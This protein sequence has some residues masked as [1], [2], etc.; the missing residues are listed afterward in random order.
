MACCTCT[1]VVGR[2]CKSV[3]FWVFLSSKRRFLCM[4]FFVLGA[5]SGFVGARRDVEINGGWPSRTYIGTRRRAIKPKGSF[6][7]LSRTHSLRFIVCIPSWVPSAAQRLHSSCVSRSE[8]R[9][10]SFSPPQM[11]A[12]GPRAHIFGILPSR[13]SLWFCSA[14]NLESV[15]SVFLGTYVSAV[16]SC[17]R[18]NERYCEA[19]AEKDSLR[20][21]P[22]GR[23]SSCVSYGRADWL[24]VFPC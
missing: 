7:L 14:L 12:L 10:C 6:T 11:V 21:S 20:L 18:R 19:F 5:I 16:T 23:N 2:E 24:R 13:A 3:F 4:F 9:A 8:C 15:H 17:C 22:P 1:E